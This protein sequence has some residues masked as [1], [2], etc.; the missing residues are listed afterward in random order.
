MCIRDRTVTT[1]VANDRDELRLVAPLLIWLVLFV[2]IL[3]I[4]CRTEYYLLFPLM[5]LEFL[6]IIPISIWMIKKSRKLRP[7]S[8]VK[9]DVILTV[10]DGM[11]YKEDMKLNVS[12]SE[13]YNEVYLDNMHDAGKYNHNFITFTA[14]IIGDDVGGFLAFCREHA[15]PIE[16]MD[17]LPEQ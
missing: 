13:W 1:H 15:V 8:Y 3:A 14:T 11:L 17:Y 4:M 2:I 16:V 5:C 7:K 9:M 6:S 10:R 12:Y